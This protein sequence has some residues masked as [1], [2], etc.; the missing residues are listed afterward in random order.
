MDVLGF[1]VRPDRR[2][3]VEERFSIPTVE[4]LDAGWASKP[5]VALVAAPTSLHLPL[6]LEAAKQGCHLFIE[7]PLGDRMDGVAQLLSTVDEKGLESMELSLKC[8]TCAH[9]PGNWV[10]AGWTPLWVQ[11]DDRACLDPFL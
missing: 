7:K 10:A 9:R 1:D 4:S 11:H 8:P 2:A 3:E 5:D 6:A